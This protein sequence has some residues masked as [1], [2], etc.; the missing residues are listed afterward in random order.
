MLHSP[1]QNEEYIFVII[2]IGLILV[3][4]VEVEVR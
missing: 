3:M 4:G 1:S 2:M